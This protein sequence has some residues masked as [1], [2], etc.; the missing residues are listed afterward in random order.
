MLTG[1]GPDVLQETVLL[2]KPVQRVVA[3]AH[4]PNE[5]AQSVGDVLAGVAAG[6]VNLSDRD[7]DGRVVLGLDDTVGSAALTWDVAIVGSACLFRGVFR[8]GDG[9]TA[10]ER[11]RVFTGQQVLL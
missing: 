8:K 1:C 7:L 10:M 3:L 9:G 6:L 2:S 11:R 4:G 5:T